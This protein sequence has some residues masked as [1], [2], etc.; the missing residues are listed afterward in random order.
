M[1][2]ILK[3][4]WAEI[5]LDAA[6]Y[7]YTYIRN[8]LQPGCRLMAVIKANAYG[9]GVEGLARIYDEEGAEWFAVSNLEEAIQLRRLG[10]RQ[11]ILILSYTPPQEAGRL[12]EY[13]ITT[14]VVSLEHARALN[15]CAAACG[16]RLT[17]HIKLD[18]G[19]T[20]VGF[21]AVDEAAEA[22]RLPCLEAEGIFTHFAAA[23]SPSEDDY[24][25]SQ[26]A[27]FCETVTALEQR[28][29]RFALRHCCNSAALMRFPEMHLDMVRPGIILYGCRPDA[30][31][32]EAWP[33]RP[34]MSLR[35]MV[36]QVKEVAA[37][38]SV[39]Y[40]RTY[41][42]A[43]RMRL[44]TV[45]IGYADGYPRVVSNHAQMALDDSRAAVV[46]R[47]CMDQ[48]MLDVTDCGK[49]EAGTIVTVFGKE[50]PAEELAGWAQTISYEILCL[51]GR[52]VPRVFLQNGCVVGAS[53]EL[54]EGRLDG[55]CPLSGPYYPQ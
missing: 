54:S 14:A 4:T 13:G 23:D 29:I 33:L 2:H 31:M 6:R 43:H 34:V 9:H 20:R 22:C 38:T 35:T 40:G 53:N 49:A 48:T 19:M 8:R 21:S 17:V 42:A 28:G 36:S 3:R 1:E 37:G 24:T 7:N 16:V 18:T 39:S 30:A 44:A 51:V 55:Y 26:F 12:A 47:V 11:R 5:D 27:R 50:L 15:D 45:P 52:R 41:C 32:P 25:R 46:G 10:L